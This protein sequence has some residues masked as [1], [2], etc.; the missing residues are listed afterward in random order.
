MLHL[1]IEHDY[2]VRVYI[3]SHVS[4]GPKLI[5]LSLTICVTDD[6]DFDPDEGSDESDDGEDDEDTLEHE[7]FIARAC[8]ETD[9]NEV[10]DLEDVIVFFAFHCG[11][12]IAP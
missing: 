6:E 12:I 8:R 1:A 4:V 11:Y 9:A 7:E 5:Y 10:Q 2:L 3:V